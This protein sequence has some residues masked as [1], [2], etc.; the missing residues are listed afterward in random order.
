L[1]HSCSD[2]ITFAA[3]LDYIALFQLGLGENGNPSC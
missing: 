3:L 1:K 2:L